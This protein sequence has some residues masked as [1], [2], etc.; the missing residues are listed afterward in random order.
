MARVLIGK[1]DEVPLGASKTFF[2]HG[3][4]ILVSNLGGTY[5]A[6]EN[7]CMHMGGMLRS[8]G[9]EKKY[10][11]SW[12]GATYDIA[13]GDAIND[14]AYGTTLKKMSVIAEGDLLYWDQT[15]EKSPWADE[16]S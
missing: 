6:Y 16:F 12:H 4:K 13:T 10:T 1:T 9:G 2:K 3:K 8:G 5:V 11:C 14:V 15:E 7:S